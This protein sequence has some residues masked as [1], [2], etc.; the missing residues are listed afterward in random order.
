MLSVFSY[1][2]KVSCPS[3]NENEAPVKNLL[4]FAGGLRRFVLQCQ[5]VFACSQY[6]TVTIRF[7]SAYLFFLFSPWNSERSCACMVMMRLSALRFPAYLQIFLILMLTQCLRRRRRYAYQ[8]SRCGRGVHRVRSCPPENPVSNRTRKKGAV[9]LP[10]FLCNA[11]KCLRAGKDVS[12]PSP[13][14]AIPQPQS[15]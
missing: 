8:F 13:V 12:I 9:P 3:V 5:L 2:I 14:T 11:D 7:Q 10:V 1:I 4:F 6:S 15:G